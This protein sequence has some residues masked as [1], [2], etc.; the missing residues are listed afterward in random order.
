MA[1]E[2]H[3]EGARGPFISVCRPENNGEACGSTHTPPPVGARA[4]ARVHRK[5]PRAQGTTWMYLDHSGPHSKSQGLSRTNP[6]GRRRLS[7][8]HVPLACPHS[9]PPPRRSGPVAADPSSE[10]LVDHR[11]HSCCSPN[12]ARAAPR[13]RPPGHDRSNLIVA[14]FCAQRG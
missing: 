10:T 5:D 12:G 2:L 3:G 7:F 14:F 1:A 11:R 4:R 6:N 13:H 9:F 8:R